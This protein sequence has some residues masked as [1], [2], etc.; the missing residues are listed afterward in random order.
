MKRFILHH[1]HRGYWEDHNKIRKTYLRIV[2]VQFIANP[3]SLQILL[4]L[5]VD[6]VKIKDEVEMSAIKEEQKD[7]GM[8]NKWW[9][10]KKGGGGKERHYFCHQLIVSRT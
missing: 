3:C 8:C 1:S 7:A 2:N 5:L 10:K 6:N 4:N 9:G